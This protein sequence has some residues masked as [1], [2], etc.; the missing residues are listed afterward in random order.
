M[1]L[2]VVEFKDLNF[3]FALTIGSCMYYMYPCFMFCAAVLAMS[4]DHGVSDALN[5]F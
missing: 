5:S 1:G 4:N 3:E 2:G